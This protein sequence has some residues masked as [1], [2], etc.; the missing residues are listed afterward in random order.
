[1]ADNKSNVGQQDRI[2][3]DANDPSEVEYLH[4]QFAHLK[5]EQV[6]EAIKSKGPLRA[7]VVKYLETL[8][9]R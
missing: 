8:N 7:D 5:H 3:V 4:R 2:R 6:V 9:K 1:M